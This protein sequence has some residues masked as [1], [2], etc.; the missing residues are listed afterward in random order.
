MSSP[1]KPVVEIPHHPIHA[2][3]IGKTPTKS[4]L[5]IQPES[6]DPLSMDVDARKALATPK[7]RKLE[8][9]KQEDMAMRPSPSKTL[10]PSS[11]AS[12]GSLTASGKKRMEV[13]IEVPPVPKGWA[14]PNVKNITPLQHRGRTGSVFSDVT[15]ADDV[16]EDELAMGSVLKSGRSSMSLGIRTGGRDERGADLSPACLGATLMPENRRSTGE[17]NRAA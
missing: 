11:S 17:A 7:K 14:T 13:Y 8:A 5:A 16:S 10:K 2:R 1:L 9:M 12:A 15:K 6:P 3:H 4:N